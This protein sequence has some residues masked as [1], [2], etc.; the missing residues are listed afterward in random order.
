MGYTPYKMKGHELKGIKQRG[1]PFSGGVG[2]NEMESGVADTI[3]PSPNKNWLK[4]M[5]KKIAGGVK[6]FAKGEGALGLLNPVG[7]GISEIKKAKEKKAQ[8]A[9]DSA[10]ASAG[11]ASGVGGGGG[12]LE[13]RIAALEAGGGGGAAAP[14]SGMNPA[15]TMMGMTPEMSGGMGGGALGTQGMAVNTMKKKSLAEGWGGAGSVDPVKAVTAMSDIRLKEKIK[16][17]GKSPSGIPIYVFSYIGDNRRYEGTMAQ[18]LISMGI[19]AVET[20]ESGYY[21]VDYSKIDVDMKL[22]N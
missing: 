4:K 7:R 15:M 13:G 8:S 19:D 5:G 3:N 9:Q 14:S 12:D 16:K 20:Q 17:A 2:S 1:V 18:D 21:S 10:A 6:K 22:I 11:T